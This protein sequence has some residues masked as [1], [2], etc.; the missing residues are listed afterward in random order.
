MDWANRYHIAYCPLINEAN[1]F[2]RGELTDREYVHFVE[3]SVSRY[4]KLCAILAT[5]Q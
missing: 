2:V 5:R 3:T 1:A 4:K